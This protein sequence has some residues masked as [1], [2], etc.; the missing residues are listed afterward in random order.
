MF[1]VLVGNK[2][3]LDSHRVI[4]Y[5]EGVNAAKEWGKYCVFFET[6]AKE[7]INHEECFHEAIRLIQK[8]QDQEPKDVIQLPETQCCSCYIL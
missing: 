3:D 8:Y 2:C 6:S 5:E 7:K 4:T 1:S